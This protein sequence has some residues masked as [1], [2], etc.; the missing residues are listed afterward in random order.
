MFSNKVLWAT[1]TSWV[2]AQSIKI[3]LG[4]VKKKKIDFSWF[5]TTG[6]MPSS[7]AAGVSTLAVCIGFSQGFASPIFALAVIFAFIT[8]FDAQTSRR[9]V[10]VQAK[11]LNLI[12]EDIYAGRKVSDRKLKELIGH[13]PVEVLAGGVL[14]IIIAVI[15]YH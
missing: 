6:G 2:I 4:F 11:I 3:I 12:M 7:H 1:I 9:S 15:F 8:M 13:T 5:I 14:G 10:G